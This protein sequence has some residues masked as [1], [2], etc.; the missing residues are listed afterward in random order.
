MQELGV[1]VDE[2]VKQGYMKHLL[3]GPLYWYALHSR[4]NVRRRIDTADSNPCIGTGGVLA[5]SLT[6][7]GKMFH[8]GL[9]HK[10]GEVKQTLTCQRATMWACF[11][12]GYTTHCMHRSAVKRVLVVNPMEL[13]MEALS[14]VQKRF[15]QDFPPHAEE[16]RYGYATPSTMKPTQCRCICTPTAAQLPEQCRCICHLDRCITARTGQQDAQFFRRS[17]SMPTPS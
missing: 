8:S 4:A 15:Y 14:V 7:R 2:L 3:G 1:G 17:L 12:T 6:A 16:A 9:P 13:V 11:A 10:A 5:W